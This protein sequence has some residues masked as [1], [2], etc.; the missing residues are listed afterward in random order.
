MIGSNSDTV[1]VQAGATAN[2]RRL[3]ALLASLA[4]AT[5]V[6]GLGFFSPKLPLPN[7]FSIFPPDKVKFGELDSAGPALLSPDGA[8]LAFIGVDADGRSQ[9]WVR[10][11]D[12]S[13]ARR[14]AGTEDARYPFW[15]PDSRDLAFFAGGKLK[16]VS[17]Q[18]GQPQTLCDAPEGS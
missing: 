3:P 12:T 17:W 5:V 11:L 14:L 4:F 6:I 18:N 1:N 7:R 2:Y 10:P 13:V 9:I 15:S 8:Q 16:R